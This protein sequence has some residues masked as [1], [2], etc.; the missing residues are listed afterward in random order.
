MWSVWNAESL[1]HEKKK[2]NQVSIFE[3]AMFLH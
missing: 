1:D 2:K 3:N